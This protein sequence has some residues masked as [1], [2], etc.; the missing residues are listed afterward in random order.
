MKTYTATDLRDY[1]YS[2]RNP[3]HET[4]TEM[5]YRFVHHVEYLERELELANSRCRR[6]E[7]AIVKQFLEKNL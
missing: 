6:L 2:R 3:E 7:Q 4:I 5:E 1:F